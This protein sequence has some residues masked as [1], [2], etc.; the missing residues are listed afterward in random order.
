MI[1]DSSIKY[2]LVS[3]LL[4]SFTDKNNF[5]GLIYSIIFYIVPV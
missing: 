1:R 5:S 2:I 3:R 4:G